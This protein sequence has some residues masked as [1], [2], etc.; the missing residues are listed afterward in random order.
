MHL[1]VMTVKRALHLTVAGLPTKSCARK[2]NELLL[3]PLQTMVTTTRLSLQA[4][5]RL[6]L[7]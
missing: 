5:P 3:M 2:H 7:G 1:I 4:T 6:H